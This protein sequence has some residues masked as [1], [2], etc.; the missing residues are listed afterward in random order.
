[1]TYTAKIKQKSNGPHKSPM[2]VSIISEVSIECLNMNVAC[3][4]INKRLPYM[5]ISTY[6]LSGLQHRVSDGS[7]HEEPKRGTI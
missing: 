3:N 4:I 2:K 7:R 6:N 1:M 5:V